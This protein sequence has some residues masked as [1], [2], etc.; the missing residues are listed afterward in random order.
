VY[1][2]TALTIVEPRSHWREISSAISCPLV[3]MIVVILSGI[4]AVHNFVDNQRGNRR[5]D[6]TV[7][8]GID[9]AKHRPTQ[10]DDHKVY[11]TGH[12]TDRTD[13]GAAL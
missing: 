13:A 12:N 6:K 4:A 1:V 2:P 5:C 11:R 10:Q 9:R 3:V 8:N 7:Q